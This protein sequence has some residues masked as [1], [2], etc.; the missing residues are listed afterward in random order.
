[1]RKK[2]GG[3]RESVARGR[4]FEDLNQTANEYYLAQGLARVEHYGPAIRVLGKTRNRLE[5]VLTGKAPPDDVGLLYDGTFAAFEAKSNDRLKTVTL[6]KRLH[7]FDALKEMSGISS[8]RPE[9]FGYL[10][11]W[12]KQPEESRITWHPIAGLE[13]EGHPRKLILEYGK[14]V[15]VPDLPGLAGMGG[16]PDWLAVVVPWLY[17]VD[18][19]EVALLEECQGENQ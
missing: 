2:G 15:V 7:Q 3:A 4:S 5:V 16:V 6:T 8:N 13:C 17:R 12:R 11:Y 1:M 9:Q 14:G 18:R 10:H 19:E